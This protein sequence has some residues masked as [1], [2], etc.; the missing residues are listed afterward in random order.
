MDSCQ[1]SLLVEFLSIPVCSNPVLGIKT[2]LGGTN[3]MGLAEVFSGSL[4][5]QF[6]GRCLFFRERIPELNF[7]R[8]TRPRFPSLPN[9]RPVQM[10]L[11]HHTPAS[12][13]HR[14]YTL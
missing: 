13:G 5:S 10:I 3:Q 7:N 1:E 2:W 8:N 12:T 9:I 4:R 11:D 6:A 14:Y